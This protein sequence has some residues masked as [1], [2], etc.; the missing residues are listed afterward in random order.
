MNDQVTVDQVTKVF[1]ARGGAVNALVD[2]QL[3]V[4]RGEFVSVIGPSGCGKSSLLRIV[5]GLLRPDT[6]SV[7]IFGDD[8]SAACAKKQ[9]GL[10]PQT[11]ALF[12]WR[13][14]LDNV[15]LPF[16]V[17]RHRHVGG[18]PPLDPVEVL[19]A[20]GL[21]AATNRRPGELSGG[22][23]QRVAVARAFVF[24]A[25]LLLMDEPFSA[26]DELTRESARQQLLALWQ[27]HR[28][29]VLFVTHSVTEAVLL[30]DRV[31]IM[32]PGPGR[33]AGEVTV[34]LPR[35]RPPGVELTEE[36]R[37][38]ELAIRRNLQAVV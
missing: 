5:A 3:S 1:P 22:M 23:A 19:D 32:T 30:S 24:G 9:V 4:Q 18:D 27:Q 7:S 2:V 21:G 16:Q 26:L 34:D 17:N 13:S 25:S 28:K 6:G 14:V 11:P 20:L 12:P 36:L 10:V 33:L 15:R 29:T 8:P 35:P 38:A 37:A 31:V